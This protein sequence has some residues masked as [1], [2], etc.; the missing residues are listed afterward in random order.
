MRAK[1]LEVRIEETAVLVRFG[2]GT[3]MGWAV[4]SSEV[5]PEVGREY[6]V[7]LDVDGSIAD[8]DPVKARTCSLGIGFSGETR[9]SGRLESVD[10]DG[11]GYFRVGVDCLLMIETSPGWSEPGT[12]I[13]MTLRASSLRITP[14]DA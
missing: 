1:I 10:A 13:A 6:G 3:G 5:E 12:L 11:M 8:F 9:L 4:W 2:S 14:F 7:E